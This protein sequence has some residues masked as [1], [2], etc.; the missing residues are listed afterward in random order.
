MTLSTCSS[1]AQCIAVCATAG[2]AALVEPLVEARRRAA[3]CWCCA[4]LDARTD[5]TAHN[6]RAALLDQLDGFKEYFLEG[7]LAKL[8]P[9]VLKQLGKSEKHSLGIECTVTCR[10]GDTKQRARRDSLR[11]V[12]FGTCAVRCATRT[13]YVNEWN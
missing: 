2:G 11:C 12:T 1:S 5:V 6:V 10:C 3:P 7:N 13:R 4:T 8:L 9:G